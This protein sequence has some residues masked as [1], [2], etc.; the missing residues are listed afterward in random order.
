MVTLPVAKTD[1][2]TQTLKTMLSQFYGMPVMTEYV[3]SFAIQLQEL[4]VVFVQLWVY[5]TI[6]YAVGAQLDM[7]GAILGE[8]RK[9]RTDDDYRGALRTRI[10]VNRSFA[11]VEEILKVMVSIEDN[12]EYILRDLGQASFELELINSIAT[13]DVS[14]SVYNQI[15]QLIKAGGVRAELLYHTS[16]IDYTFN[17]ADGDYYQSG[18]RGGFSDDAESLG[19]YFADIY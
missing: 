14:Y 18:N 4:E 13:T 8:S 5:R 1:I 16:E 17:F 12:R 11:T 7:L 10:L 9:S 15:L 19:G 6:D 2:V 3:K